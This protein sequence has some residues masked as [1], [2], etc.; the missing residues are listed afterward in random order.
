[1]IHKLSLV[2]TQYLRFREES[3]IG[4]LGII[5]RPPRELLQPCV[6]RLLRSLN[7]GHADGF[8]F[9]TTRDLDLLSGKVASLGLACFIQAVDCFA[10][11]IGENEL[12]ITAFRAHKCT[13]FI[14]PH[15]LH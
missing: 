14:I 7:A 2:L 15:S 11:T 8:A 9:Y 10:V 12:A 13:G 1:M 5:H 4:G 6:E 3:S